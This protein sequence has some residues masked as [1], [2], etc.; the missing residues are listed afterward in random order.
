MHPR[1]S[2]GVVCS[3]LAGLPGPPS[4]STTCPTSLVAGDPQLLAVAGAPLSAS[5]EEENPRSC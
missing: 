3:R 1:F 2:F 4:A 5:L